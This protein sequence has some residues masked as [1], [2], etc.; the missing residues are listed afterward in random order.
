MSLA[1]IFSEFVSMQGMCGA[2]NFEVISIS[3]Y[4]K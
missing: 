3:T 1:F 2:R 4:D